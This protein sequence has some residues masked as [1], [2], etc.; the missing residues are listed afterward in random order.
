MLGPCR[1]K[2][3]P[4][5]ACCTHHPRTACPSPLERITHGPLTTKPAPCGHH[6][7]PQVFTKYVPNV[8]RERVTPAAVQAA[9]RRSCA[10]LQVQQLDLVQMHW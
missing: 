4:R 6:P 9:V 5:T 10:A 3:L 7:V 2:S 1:H 8:Y